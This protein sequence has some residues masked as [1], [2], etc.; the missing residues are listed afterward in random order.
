MLPWSHK[1]N[2]LVATAAA[3]TGLAV[4]N[5]ASIEAWL[6]VVVLGLTIIFL[7]FGIAMR[8][9]RFVARM[10][11]AFFGEPISPAE[12]KKEEEETGEE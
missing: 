11:R 7:L 10:S 2:D 6:Q 8:A 4:I 9:E 5:L 1:F 12:A 3:A